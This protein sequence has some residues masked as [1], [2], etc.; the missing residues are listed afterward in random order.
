[1]TVTV[2]QFIESAARKARVIPI[3]QNIPDDYT[4]I[5]VE[6]FNDILDQF[7][8]AGVSI[9]Y[10][11]V[12]T[13]NTVAGQESYLIGPGQA[14]V[15]SDQVIEIIDCW[16]TLNNVRYPLGNMNELMYSNIVYPITQGIPA[17]YKLR[18]FNTYSQLTLQPVPWTNFVATLI[19]KQRLQEVTQTTTLTEIPANWNLGLKLMIARDF[20][21]YLALPQDD[22]F[23]ARVR[24]AELDLYA[25]NVIDIFV[26]KNEILTHNR[27][28]YPYILGFF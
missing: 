19:C 17:M 15:N 2:A 1:M 27:F 25:S 20:R 24:K 10:Q 28:Y 11:S 9:P 3:G 13:F 22:N 4:K 6:I 7:G 21:D 18:L 8:G 5:G 26:H 16:V 14:D 23:L 12:L